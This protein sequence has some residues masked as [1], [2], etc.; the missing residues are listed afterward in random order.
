MTWRCRMSLMWGCTFMHLS[1]EQFTEWLLGDA[2]DEVILHL[3]RCAACR[4]EAYEL[5]ETI[6]NCIGE[7]GYG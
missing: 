6:S 5:R 2:G 4:D 3:R 1:D 7:D